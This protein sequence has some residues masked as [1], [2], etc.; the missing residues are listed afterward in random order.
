MPDRYI[1]MF[2]TQRDV[3]ELFNT[4]SKYTPSSERHKIV[5]SG[6]KF[7]MILMINNG[8]NSVA[9]TSLNHR[10]QQLFYLQ[11]QSKGQQ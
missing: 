11:I 4:F 9:T 3:S 6:Q 2:L 1:W 5:K 7:Q 10:K 8:H